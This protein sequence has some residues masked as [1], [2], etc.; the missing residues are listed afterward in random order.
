VILRG[1]ARTNSIELENVGTLVETSAQS[2][3]SGKIGLNLS[4]E[5]SELGP[6][7]EGELVAKIGDAEVRTPTVV[8]RQLRVCFS[9]NYVFQQNLSSSV[10]KETAPMGAAEIAQAIARAWTA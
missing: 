6:Q 3:D 2:T 9:E 10:R 7:E 4:I 8:R 5:Q 1:D